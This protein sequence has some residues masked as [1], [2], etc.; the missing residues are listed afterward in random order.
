[1]FFEHP[2]ENGDAKSTY[3]I[4][5]FAIPLKK[6]TRFLLSRTYILDSFSRRSS[7]KVILWS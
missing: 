2:C 5:F 1:M 7:S 3:S 4:L 6:E